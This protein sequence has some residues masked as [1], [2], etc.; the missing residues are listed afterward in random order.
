MGVNGNILYCHSPPKPIMSEDGKEEEGMDDVA[1]MEE[2]ISDNKWE[3]TFYR[4]TVSTALRKERKLR[5]KLG[6]NVNVLT[7]GSGGVDGSEDN[8]GQ[9][10]EM[11]DDLDFFDMISGG[12]ANS[13]TTKASGGKRGKKHKSMQKW[14]KKG[15]KNRN[16]DPYGCHSEPD[17]ELFGVKG[18]SGLIVS[19]GKYGSSNYTRP[20]Y[21]GT[22]SAV[23]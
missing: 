19:A 14:G 11:D 23:K 8:K 9:E 22:K 6:V 15:R 13:T 2:V 16:K 12:E 17:D 18:G 7:S 4:E 3:D 10:I 5:E 1:Q 21:R 20:T